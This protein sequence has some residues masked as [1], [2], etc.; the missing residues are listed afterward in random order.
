MAQRELKDAEIEGLLR[1]QR[2]VRIAFD[3]FGERY[4]L[5]LGYV[6]REGMLYLML[7]AG[8]KTRMAAANPR[9]AFQVDDAAETGLL[10]W[11]SVTGEGEIAW[12][13]DAAEKSVIRSL[14]LARFPELAAWGREQ[15]QEKQ[16]A[17]A[18]LFACLRP[19]VLTG[20]SFRA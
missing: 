11:S 6:W 19:I 8:R 14:L 3:A 5:P 4:L 15:A 17:G 20:R 7:S 12:V 2:I 10:S 1:S 18:L 16:A 13:E 9:V